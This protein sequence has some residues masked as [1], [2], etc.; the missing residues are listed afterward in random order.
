MRRIILSTI[1]V[2]AVAASSALAHGGFPTKIALPNGV[3][4]R[5]DRDRERQHC[6]RRLSRHG[7]HLGGRSAHRRGPHPGRR[8]SQRAFGDRHRIRPRSALGLG[9]ALWERAPLRR[10]N[11]GADQ[12][13]AACDRNRRDV[14]QRR[15]RDEASRVL[16]RLAAARDLQGRPLQR[17]AGPGAV[18]TIPLGGD[19]QHVAGQFNLN[20]IVATES[21]KTLI[22]VQT[23]SRKLLRIDPEV[24]RRHDDRPRRLRPL[25]RRRSAPARP[26]AVRRPEPRQQGCGLPALT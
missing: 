1:A 21:G 6:L 11:G 5:G 8:R 19:Y 25:E 9:R 10:S 17:T 23:V 16:H 15:G 14:H 24:R 2:L 20:G 12:G 4:S 7:R 13:A 26:D 18:T 22:A 3:R